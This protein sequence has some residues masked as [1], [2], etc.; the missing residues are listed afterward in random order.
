VNLFSW[1]AGI[2]LLT[3]PARTVAQTIAPLPE[4]TPA[5]IAKA[6]ADSARYPYT[7]ADIRFMS[8]MIG[9]HAQAIVI[10][11]W[12]PTHGASPMIQR[13][14]ARIINAQQDEIRLMQ[15]W[16]GDRRQPIP[17]PEHA[18]MGHGE[19]AEHAPMM[20]MLSPAQLA[21]LD[22]TRGPAFDKLFLKF[23]IQHH[24]GAITMVDRL[25]A[26]DGA[27]QDE[28]VFR[29]ATDVQVDQRTEVARMERM[30]AELI[31]GA[32]DQ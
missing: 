10:S 22:A 4:S 30:L 31:F 16:L 28:G 15:V 2:L 11:R 17:D 9:H 19:H 3:I 23:M 13:L 26:T 8:D 5:A 12:A 29:F 1:G 32:A 25:F 6:Q 20:G 7:I 21:E 18:M 27:A 14:A 24:S